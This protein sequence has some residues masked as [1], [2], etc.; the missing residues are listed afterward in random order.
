MKVEALKKRLERNRPMTTITIRIPEDVIEDLK[1]VAPLLGF[2]GYQPLIRAYIG[3][4]LRADLERLEGDTISALVASLKRHGV[5]DE[6]LQEA[7][8]EITPR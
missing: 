7:L 8:S 2:S 6:L 5:S 3:Q 4:G 1:R